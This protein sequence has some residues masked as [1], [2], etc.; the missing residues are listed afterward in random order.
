MK[1][2][3][4]SINFRRESLERIQLCN[5]IIREYMA[6]D[7]KLTLRQ[8]YYQL[9]SKQRHPQHREVVQGARRPRL[10]R[11]PRRPHRLGRHR[12]PQPRAGHLGRVRKCPGVG[13]VDGVTL[14]PPPLG[15]AGELR[16]AVG[17]KGGLGRR[18]APA[19]EQVPRHLDGEPRLL[20]AERDVRERPAVPLLQRA[21]KNPILFYLG[22]TTRAARTW[23]A[24]SRTA[25]RCSASPA[26]C[27]S[28]R[29]P[30][31]RSASTTRPRT[32]PR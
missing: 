32:R 10:R 27:A 8:L 20:V 28:W 29:S 21:H 24:T 23:C 19:R 9:V 1:R 13:R 26:T 2:A 25:S 6:Q 30:W 31:S 7:L 14:P 16:R 11:A 12:G 5:E 4:K 3:Y 22:T 15:W 17:G 18:A